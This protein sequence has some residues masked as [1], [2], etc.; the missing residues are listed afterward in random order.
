[1]TKPIPPGAHLDEALLCVRDS[2]PLGTRPAKRGLVLGGDLETR[3]NGRRPRNRM[4]QGWRNRP[5]QLRNAL[6]VAQSSQGE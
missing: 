1:M 3:R 5:C 2:D 4:E 6:Q